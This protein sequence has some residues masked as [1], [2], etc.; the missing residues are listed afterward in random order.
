MCFSPLSVKNP[1]SSNQKDR[2]TVP[3]GKCYACRMNKRVAW[4]YRIQRELMISKSAYFITLTYSDENLPT[5]VNYE[6]GEICGVLRKSDVQSFIKRLRYYAGL[7][8]NKVR[9]FLVGEYGEKTKRPHYHLLLFNVDRSIV[10]SYIQEQ[11]GFGNVDIGR[12]EAASIHYCTKDMMKDK[13]KN[14][15]CGVPGFFLMSKRPAIG[16]CAIKDMLNKKLANEF[17]VFMNGYKTTMPR[18][19]RDKVFSIK[20]REAHQNEMIVKADELF[21]EYIEHCTKYGILK[22]FEYIEQQRKGLLRREEKN[23]KLRKL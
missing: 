6:T 10:V 13:T 11:W 23:L 16:H 3:C 15:I 14:K 9:Y 18:Y 5:R 4:T 1:N 7:M 19:Y 17:T 12:V 21:N 2:L 20:E 22:P 8:G